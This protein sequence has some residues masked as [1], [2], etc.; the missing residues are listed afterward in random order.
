MTKANTCLVCGTLGH[1]SSACK[2][3][4][5]PPDGFY[6]GGGGGGGHSHDDDD[7]KLQEIKAPIIKTFSQQP[8]KQICL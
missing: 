2:S 3:L 8:Y 4:G 7:E 1:S 6:T 5:V